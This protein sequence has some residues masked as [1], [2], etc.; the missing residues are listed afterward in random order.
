MFV[1]ETLEPFWMQMALMIHR[2]FFEKK[3]QSFWFFEK[4]EI[5]PQKGEF[6]N[7]FLKKLQRI[8][9]LFFNVET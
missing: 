1:K 3:M 2:E 7:F 6:L 8:L 4:H 5:N 9:F